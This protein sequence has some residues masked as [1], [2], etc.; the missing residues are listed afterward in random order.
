MV[1][2]CDSC[3]FFA[4]IKVNPTDFKVI[5]MDE[6]GIGCNLEDTK[7]SANCDSRILSQSSVSSQ[8]RKLDPGTVC[9]K[10][11]TPTIKK[12]Y[13]QN[14][15]KIF[16]Q[17]DFTFSKKCCQEKLMNLLPPGIMQ[18][19]EN[20]K[21][22][23]VGSFKPF[24][25][26]CFEDKDK[27]TLIY[28]CV[29]YLYPY[30]NTDCVSNEIIVKICVKFD[31]FKNFLGYQHAV[32]FIRFACLLS[33]E[34]NCHEYSIAGKLCTLPYNHTQTL[35]QTIFLHIPVVFVLS[36]LHVQSTVLVMTVSE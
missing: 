26:G 22:T 31:D 30:L 24:S 29:R 6:N 15:D 20:C 25:L 16:Q 1:S 34:E 35:Y 13:I 17:T 23:D 14:S 28:K 2:L 10:K 5:E 21:S 32:S 33:Y 11:E 12:R 7:R 4:Q 18:L 19:L 36:F 3:G 9:Q 8:K 27:R